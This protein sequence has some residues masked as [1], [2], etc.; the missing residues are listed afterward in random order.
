LG[1]GRG[2][3]GLRLREAK[4]DTKT[5]G[6]LLEPVGAVIGTDRRGGVE[7][8]GDSGIARRVNLR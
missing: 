8:G 3:E 5:S 7:R 6:A 2:K 4:R 1:G